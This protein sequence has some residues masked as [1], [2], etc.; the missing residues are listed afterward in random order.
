MK[1]WLFT[2]THD[3][4]VLIEKEDPVAGPGQ[5]VIDIKASG[6]CHSDVSAM[7]HESWMGL[8]RGAP[9]IFGHECAGVVESVG[10]GVTEVKPGDRVGVFAPSNKDLGEG[11]GY[12]VDGGY[13]TKVLVYERQCVLMPD[14]VTFEQG[15]AGTD[16]GATSYRALFA[17]GGAK[18]GMKVGIVGIGGLGQFALGMAL[19]K[20]CD[21]YAVDVNPEARELAKEMGCQHVYEN[22]LD[23]KE[24]A[25]EVIV[26][27]AGFGTTTD[28]AIKAVAKYGRVVL[29]GMAV[30]KVTIDATAL[31]GIILKEV[32]LMGSCGSVASDVAGVYDILK[33]GKFK[34]LLS[35]ISFEE[36]GEG[37]ETLK[38]GGVKGRLVAV[39]D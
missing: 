13:A 32:K 17:I 25:P 24:V 15:A 36:I 16:A 26:D 8:I 18:E 35:T 11:I 34:P 6:L 10:E 28:D 38:R 33:T 21:C 19:A 31:D 37:L 5:V 14:E 27:F 1:G 39:Q 29:V 22:V 12:T 3:P 7:E 9:L 2:K 4:L 30:D 20:G 23:L